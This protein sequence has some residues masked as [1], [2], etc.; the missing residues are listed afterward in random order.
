MGFRVDATQAIFDDSDEYLLSAMTRQARAR[1][2]GSSCLPW[3]KRATID[4]AAAALHGR[5]GWASTH[6]GR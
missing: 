3:R 4:E 1:Q 5:R 6:S 2:G